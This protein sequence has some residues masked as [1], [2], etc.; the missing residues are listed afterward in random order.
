MQNSQFDKTKCKVAAFDLD[1]TILNNGIL[2][3]HNREALWDLHR[4][5][6]EV[7]VSTGRHFQMIPAAVGSLPFVRYAI[8][9]SGAHVLD[10]KSGQDISFKPFEAQVA[11]SL[12]GYCLAYAQLSHIYIRDRIL[13]SW[14]DLW[15]TA[16]RLR[17][18]EVKSQRVALT[19]WARIVYSPLDYVKRTGKRIS[20]L[21]AFFENE[22]TCTA[23][24]ERI[25]GEFAVEAVTTGG[26]DIEVTPGGV[27]KGVGLSQL[28]AHLGVDVKDTIVFGDSPNDIEIMQ[29]GG[30]AVAMGNANDDVKSFADFVAP[31]VDEDGAAQAMAVLFA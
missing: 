24:L 4:S 1:G 14:K 2:S 18:T 17:N 3:A 28:C 8:T 27:T 13:M 16:Q 29:C 5:G 7:V 30:Y 19:K 22:A 20:K 15:A 21:N 9:S 31:R 25:R 23:V 12:A 11:A 6:V 26:I 10:L